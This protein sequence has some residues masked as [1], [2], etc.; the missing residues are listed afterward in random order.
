MLPLVI[1]GSL[2]LN[3]TDVDV[4]DRA[5]GGVTSCG[6]ASAVLATVDELTVQPPAVHTATV[7]EYTVNAVKPASTYSMASAGSKLNGTD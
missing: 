2:Q 3:S 1:D 6:A 4:T 5:V 7:Y